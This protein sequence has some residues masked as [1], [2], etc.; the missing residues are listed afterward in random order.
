MTNSN[1]NK[2]S[3]SDIWSSVRKDL[4]QIEWKDP[5]VVILC[6]ILIFLTAGSTWNV[7]TG[8]AKNAVKVE[9]D[10]VY[11]G[12][13][14]GYQ[15]I[16]NEAEVSE[17]IVNDLEA[18]L[19]K[20]RRFEVYR[21]H[22]AGTSAAV[23]DRIAKIEKDDP[24]FVV[25]VHADGHPNAELTGMHIYAM[26]PANKNHDASLKLANAIAST[27]TDGTWGVST[28]YLYYQ[29]IDQSE[30]YE[31]KFVAADDTT[32][33]QLDTFE[34]MKQ[35]DVPV[36]VTNQFYVTNQANVDQW[37]NE[38]GYQKAAQNIYDAI[39]DYNGFERKSS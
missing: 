15:G 18:L 21:T 14:L 11:G 28:G 33:Y 17:N 13:D 3:S 24:M 1:A 32:D 26:P 35:A 19:K 22:E 6:M 25:S 34:L 38:E 16:V 8:K 23:S 39:C 29:Q 10:A 12:E 9:L 31:M 27:F 37:A 4:K 2:S 36:V 30:N 7:V 5:I 20:D